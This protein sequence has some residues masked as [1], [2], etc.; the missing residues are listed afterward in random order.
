[1]G[2]A[3]IDTGTHGNITA[4]AG[5]GIIFLIA[6]FNFTASMGPGVAGLTYVGESSSLRLRTKTAAIALALNVF[7][8]TVCNTVLPYLIDDIQTQSGYVFFGFG[9]I[10]TTIIALWIPDLTGR[11]YAEIDELFVTK[12]PSRKFDKTA[13]TGGS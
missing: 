2:V 6:L 3:L 5:T 4:S 10:C 12:V 1:M 13:C 8:G 7:V 11:T 9:A